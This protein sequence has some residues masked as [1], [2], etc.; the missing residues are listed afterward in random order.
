AFAQID[1]PV[2]AETFDRLA[3]RGIQ[4]D[5]VIAAINKDAQLV[6]RRAVAPRGDAAVDE[7]GAVRRLAILVRFWIV[8][9]QLGA[10][11]GVRPDDAVI[12]RAEVEHVV[13]HDRRR[14]EIAGA[15]A[16]G[17]E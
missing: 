9:P 12:R 10:G 7:A 16:E 14:L 5:Q 8:A 17:F 6:A 13:D 1:R 15:R 4:A 11:V 3:G 2:R